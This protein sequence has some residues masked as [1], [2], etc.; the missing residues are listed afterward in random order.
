MFVKFTLLVCLYV[1]FSFH[2]VTFHC[3]RFPARVHKTPVDG[4]EPWKLCNQNENL[5]TQEKQKAKMEKISRSGQR[6]SSRVQ[7]VSKS[8]SKWILKLPPLGFI[9]VSISLSM[10]RLAT[11]YSDRIAN[12]LATRHFRHRRC[13][14][15]YLKT[16]LGREC[17]RPSPGTCRYLGLI[18]IDSELPPLVFM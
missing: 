12:R 3:P 8:Y 11:V 4:S 14:I 15:Y 7:T 6:D 2:L 17:V 10:L 18:L 5:K 9:Q 1:A 16:S 13:P